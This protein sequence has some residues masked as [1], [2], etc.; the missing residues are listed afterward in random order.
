[1]SKI[2]VM[3]RNPDLDAMMAGWLLIRFDSAH[4][5]DAELTFIPAGSTYKNVAVD[6]DPHVTHVDV[7]FG[8]FDHHQPGA[9][10]TCAS[11]LVW[12]ELVSQ[13]LISPSDTGVS[14]MVAHAY[15][16]D[17][18]DDC[19]WKEATEP[20]FAFTL[21]EIIPSLHRLQTLDNAAVARAGFLYLDGVYQRLKDWEKGKQAIAMGSEFESLWGK[22]IVVV[23]GADDVSKVAQ[24]AGYDIVV[25]HDPEKGYLKIKL[26]PDVKLNLDRLY[27]KITTRESKKRWFYHNSGLMLFSGSDKGSAKEKTEL[28]P[29]DILEMI[30]GC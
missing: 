15:Q 21:A 3:H 22:G 20:R 29:A 10:K 4:Y 14:A 19:F 17:H 12:E 24:R 18:F 6:T 30:R 1:M 25:V 7:G 16:I 26:K 23:T 5:G 2:I 28:T 9:K 13:G 27:V 8:K 11:K